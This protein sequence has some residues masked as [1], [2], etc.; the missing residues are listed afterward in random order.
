METKVYNAIAV[1]AMSRD[2]D[3]L[4]CVA[5]ATIET[6]GNIYL[7]RFEPLWKYYTGV[8][9]FA[10]STGVTQDT[11]IA[12]Q[13]TSWGPM[14]VMGSVAREMGFVGLFPQLASVDLGVRFALLKLKKIGEIYENEE[15]VISAYNAGT[16]KKLINGTWSNQG[17]VSK[18]TEVLFKLRKEGI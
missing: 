7:T 4:L 16:P 8:A 12:G 11:E 5:I 9:Q 3:P 17:Y 2:L 6:H 18:V 1:Q 13:A 10:H 14:Q 15:A